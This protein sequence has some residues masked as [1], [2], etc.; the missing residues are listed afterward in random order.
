MD[1]VLEFVR[2]APWYRGLPPPSW[3]VGGKGELNFEGR[4]TGD[5][6]WPFILGGCWLARMQALRSIDW[7]DRRL[8]KMGEDVLLGE[9]FRQ[10]GWTVQHI[11]IPGVALDTEPRRGHAGWAIFPADTDAVA[12]AKRIRLPA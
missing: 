9:A 7:P 11:G 3:R 5:G 4:G 1:N 6:R 12:R 10:Q 2:T 8:V